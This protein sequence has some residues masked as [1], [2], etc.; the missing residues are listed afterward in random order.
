MTKGGICL[1]FQDVFLTPGDVNGFTAMTSTTFITINPFPNATQSFIQAPNSI[2]V[3]VQGKPFEYVA[4]NEAD[5]AENVGKYTIDTM[6][7]LVL[8][9]ETLTITDCCSCGKYVS[10]IQVHYQLKPLQ[11]AD[12]VPTYY[13]KTYN[14][15]NYLVT[16]SGPAPLPDL[17]AKAKAIDENQDLNVGGPLYHVL[18]RNMI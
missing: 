10:G 3:S 8:I 17:L 5:Q 9:A 15:N 13:M 2:R 12:K 1:R 6:N 11:Y 7:R 14:C 16:A 18:T 4:Y